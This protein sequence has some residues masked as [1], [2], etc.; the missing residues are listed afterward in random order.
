M[1]TEYPINQFSCLSFSAEHG[2]SLFEIILCMWNYQKVVEKSSESQ[3]NLKNAVI[4][5]HNYR[6]TENCFLSWFILQKQ[7]LL[8]PKMQGER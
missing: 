8:M 6:K 2:Q 1:P 4:Q 3:L 7:V 5:I